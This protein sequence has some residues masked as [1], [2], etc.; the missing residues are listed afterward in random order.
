MGCRFAG[1]KFRRERVSPKGADPSSIRIRGGRSAHY[2]T[3]RHVLVWGLEQGLNVMQTK[4]LFTRLMISIIG[5]TLLMTAL[6]FNTSTVL[7]QT[8]TKTRVDVNSADVKT[9]ETLPGIGPTI[10]DRIVAGRPYKNADDLSKVKG[11]SKS[12]VEAFQDQI[13]YGHGTT[14]AK[15]S[16]TTS[17]KKTT[18]PE[19][20]TTETTP[21]TKT[22]SSTTTH[23]S[24]STTPSPTGSS[25]GKL[26]PGQTVNI[27][28]A[29]AEELDV[30]PGIGPTK[31]QAIIDFRNEHGRFSSIEDIQNVKGIKGGE[32]S[33]IKDYIRVR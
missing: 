20:T 7:G 33:K 19:T 1:L 14:T 26:A 30:L 3:A 2:A 4:S 16:T 11:L 13:T 29:S 12:K 28:T 25:S 22:K 17:S 23:S 24:G 10:A 5:P 6:A 9:L 18:T 8:T 27:N 15:K 32:F 21:S 31:A